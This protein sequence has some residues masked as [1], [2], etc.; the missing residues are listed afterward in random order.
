MAAK[1]QCFGQHILLTECANRFAIAHR[2]ALPVGETLSRRVSPVKFTIHLNFSSPFPS[3]GSGEFRT[4]RSATKGSAF[5]NR[6]PLKRL[7]RNFCLLFPFVTNFKE[8]SPQWALNSNMALCININGKNQR[9][10]EKC[11]H[12]GTPIE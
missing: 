7:D 12:S 6:K 11:C 3:A 5:G 4:L 10:A 9:N 8:A 2:N 1:P